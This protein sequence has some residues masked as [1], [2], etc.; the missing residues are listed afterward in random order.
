[1]RFLTLTLSGTDGNKFRFLLPFAIWEGAGWKILSAIMNQFEN[2][3]KIFK[4]VIILSKDPVP[5]QARK[6]HKER[7]QT[8]LKQTIYQQYAN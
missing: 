6:T 5:Y 4:F 2:V 7:F 3:N 8:N 1:M